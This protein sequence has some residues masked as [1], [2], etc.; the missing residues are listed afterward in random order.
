MQVYV[1]ET[2]KHNTEFYTY[3]MLN[4]MQSVHLLGRKQLY[5]YKY[6]KIVYR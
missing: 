3:Q 4:F 1:S 5:L 2:L 6:L